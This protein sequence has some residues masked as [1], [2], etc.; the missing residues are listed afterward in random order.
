MSCTANDLLLIQKA[1]EFVGILM[2]PDM[3]LTN[4][5]QRAKIMEK[6]DILDSIHE[7]SIDDE[8]DAIKVALEEIRDR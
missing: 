7:I 3:D 6:S 8:L 2:L 4:D 1:K 5:S